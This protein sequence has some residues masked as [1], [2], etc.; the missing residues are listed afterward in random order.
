MIMAYYPSWAR[1]SYTYDKVDYSQFNII[2]HAFIF[3]TDTGGLRVDADFLYPELVTSVHAKNKKILVSLGDTFGATTFATILGNPAKKQAFIQA[4]KKFITDNKY[5]GVDVDWEVPAN[6]QEGI[7]LVQFIRDLKSTLS[8]KLVTATISIMPNYIDL[9]SLSTYADY[10]NIMAYDMEAGWNGYAGYNAPL[11]H[12]AKMP[13][14]MSVDYFM[15][16]IFLKSGINKNKLILGFPLY[17]RKFTVQN[18]YDT[19]YQ[20]TPVEYK[21][22]P[23]DCTRKW[24]AESLVP[25][26]SCTGYYI[27]YDDAQ[28][29]AYKKSYVDKAGLGGIFFWALGQ[30]NGIITTNIKNATIK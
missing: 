4:I 3:P 11:Y 17:G 13:S 7:M 21:D 12:N 14:D 9:P 16:T 6:T 22:L 29:Y 18:P 24:D 26:L 27:T 19:A 8:G 2:T 20:S 1:Y 15:R 23:T 5:D 10:I 25:Y 28:S 30:D